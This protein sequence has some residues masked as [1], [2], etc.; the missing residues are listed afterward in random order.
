MHR[1]RK[2]HIDLKD[3]PAV[4]TATLRRIL[5]LVAPHRWRIAGIGTCIVGAAALNLVAP[6]FIKRIVDIAIPERNLPL[7]FLC[8]AAMIAGPVG[9]GL[10]QMLQKYSAE[11]IGQQVTLD[12]R[13]RMYRQLHDMPFDFFARQKPGEAVSHVLNDVQG[14]GSVV[15]N[16]LVDL[17]QNTVVLTS[18]LA[19]VAFLDWRLALL[20]AAFLP[21]FVGSARRVGRRRKHLKRSLQ[22]RVSEL[23]GILTET[24]SVSGALLVKAFGNEKSEVERLARKLEAIRDLSL[25]QSLVGRWFQLVL[26]LFESIGP[27]L[28]FAAGGALVI[29]GQMPLGTVIAFVGVLKRLYN[30]ASALAG[31]HVDLRTSYAYFDRIFEV[32]DRTPSIRNAESA[33]VPASV[34]GQVEFRH[35]SLSYDDSGH[36]ISD[37]SLTIPAGHVVGLVGPS[38]AG[39]SSLASLLMRLYDPTAGTVLIDGTDVRQFDLVALRQHIAVVTQDTFLFH[40][41]IIENLRYAKPTATRAEVEAA[42]RQAQI[43]DVIMALPR[44]YDTMVGER[45][46]RFSGGERQRLSIARAILKNPSILILDEATSALDTVSER[47][48]QDALLPLLRGRTS[49]VIAHRLATVRDADRIVVMSDGAIVEDGTHDELVASKGLYDWLWRVQA[50]DDGRRAVRITEDASPDPLPVRVRAASAQRR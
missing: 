37:L 20:A 14:V 9:A 31:A 16:T 12:L 45:G 34:A 19:F 25:R 49:L 8:C 29:K 15:S 21:L 2:P 38:G 33:V 26:G 1:A 11:Y 13:V 10:L 22:A 28:V 23:T 35:V 47:K 46:Y 3:A 17:V 4:E 27:A 6:F 40:A 30:P 18:T 39:K 42:A 5:A 43:H 7:L 36:A 24:L 44:G 41:P 50:R 48:V 32:M